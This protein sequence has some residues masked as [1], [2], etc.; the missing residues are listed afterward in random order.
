[1]QVIPVEIVTELWSFYIANDRWCL[2]MLSGGLFAL[3]NP[4]P[5]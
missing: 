2:W 5:P 4:Y 1:M 3:A